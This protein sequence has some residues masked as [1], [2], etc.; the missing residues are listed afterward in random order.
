L[1][2]IL[3]DAKIKYNQNYLTAKI[4][5]KILKKF[6]CGPSGQTIRRGLFVFVF[7]TGAAVFS[8]LCQ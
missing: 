4:I 7:F 1:I 8:K 3:V 5:I 6:F 2:N